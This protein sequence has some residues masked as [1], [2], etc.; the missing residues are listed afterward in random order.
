[1]LYVVDKTICCYWLLCKLHGNRW[2][3]HLIIKYKFNLKNIL[4]HPRPPF[5]L[6]QYL[7]QF[8]MYHRQG[9][10]SKTSTVICLFEN[11][12]I[13]IYLLL[14]SLKKLT[15][16]MKT[17]K[18]NMVFWADLI[19]GK[20]VTIILNIIMLYTMTVNVNVNVNEFNT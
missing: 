2:Y 6:H 13:G 14:I 3:L 19:Y 11:V 10:K 1:M 9:V 16:D 8:W 7:R 18:Y 15:K 5:S 17:R 20:F 12:S 4:L